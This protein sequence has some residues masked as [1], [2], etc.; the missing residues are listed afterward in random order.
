MRLLIANG[1]LYADNLFFSYVEAGNGRTDLQPG[2]YAV[3]ARHSHSHQQDLP[4]AD[5][6]G[7]FGPALGSD[8][9]CDIVLGRVRKGNVILPCAN[10]V[11][12]LLA[13]VEAAEDRGQAISLVIE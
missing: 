1:T 12:R 9:E 4:V 2:R 3:E 8:V 7:W 5:G 10:H 6:I 11:R 13:L